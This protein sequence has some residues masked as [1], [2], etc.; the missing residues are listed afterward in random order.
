MAQGAIVNA[1]ISAQLFQTIN[2][3]MNPT[4]AILLSILIVILLITFLVTSA[5]SGILVMNTLASGGN[6]KKREL[7]HIIL[8]GL[9]FSI[10]IAVL[11][12]AVA[13]TPQICDDYRR[14]SIFFDFSA[15][16][17]ALVK[18]ILQNK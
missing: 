8:W 14:P 18:T 3:F 17:V 4:M 10:M 12:M 7:K 1:D 2:L 9:L 11:L 13:W 15:M 6:T 5:D 16:P